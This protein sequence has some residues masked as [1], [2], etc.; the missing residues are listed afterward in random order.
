MQ[1]AAKY[2]H[3]QTLTD[4]VSLAFISTLLTTDA[5]SSSMMWPWSI[6]DG[7]DSQVSDE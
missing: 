4:A 3:R 5:E 1:A 6:C 2:T 7:Q